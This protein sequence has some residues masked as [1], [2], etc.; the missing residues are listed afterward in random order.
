MVIWKCKGIIYRNYL[1]ERPDA[2]LIFYLSEGALSQGGRLFKP[3]RSLKKC[4]VGTS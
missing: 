2:H 4:K 3:G 1:N